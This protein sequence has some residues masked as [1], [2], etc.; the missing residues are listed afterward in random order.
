MASWFDDEELLEDGN[1]DADADMDTDT[2]ADTDAD[3]EADVKEFKRPS[4]VIFFRLLN[5]YKIL[6]KLDQFIQFTALL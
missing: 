1:A 3:A 5:I 2:D 4:N 6:S